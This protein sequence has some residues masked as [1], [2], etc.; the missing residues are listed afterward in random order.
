MSGPKRHVF[1]FV[2]GS[3]EFSRCH[4]FIS[5]F[6]QAS[7]E[8]PPFVCFTVSPCISGNQPTQ[9]FSVLFSSTSALLGHL[10]CSLAKVFLQLI[11]HSQSCRFCIGDSWILVSEDQH[12]W[13]LIWNSTFF[14]ME[15]VSDV[16]FA[17]LIITKVHLVRATIQQPTWHWMHMLVTGR[18]VSGGVWWNRGGSTNVRCNQIGYDDIRRISLHDW[19][20]QVESNQTYSHGDIQY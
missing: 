19:C 20:E 15:S 5:T 6:V 1:F 10:D 13:M 7:I 16:Y 2:W 12:H 3:I 18:S 9:D 4:I 17:M 11:P 14:S 8:F